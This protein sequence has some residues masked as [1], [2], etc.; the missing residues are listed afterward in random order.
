MT[1]LE[2]VADAIRVAIIREGYACELYKQLRLNT[3][4][5]ELQD[6]FGDLAQQELEHKRKLEFELIKQGNVNKPIDTSISLDAMEYLEELPSPE[7]MDHKEV[8]LFGIA[9]ERTS[10]QFYTLLAG[11]ITDR[12]LQNVLLALAEEEAKHIQRFETA[13]EQSISNQD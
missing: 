5:P 13:Y 10:F 12:E 7:G 11:T 6:L 2:T 8:M 9:K 3:D 1:G 4:E